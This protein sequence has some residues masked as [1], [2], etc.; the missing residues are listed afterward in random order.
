MVDWEERRGHDVDMRTGK[1]GK[2]SPCSSG[3]ASSNGT[4]QRRRWWLQSQLGEETTTLATVVGYK[5][6]EEEE[7]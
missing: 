1:G 7:M 4:N 2:V 5:H 3:N 6:L